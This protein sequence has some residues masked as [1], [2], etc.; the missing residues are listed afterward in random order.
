VYGHILSRLAYG[1]R[2]LI[3]AEISPVIAFVVDVDQVG[4]PDSVYAVIDAGDIEKRGLFHHG[5]YSS[6]FASRAPLA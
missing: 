2:Y 4:I 3:H 6:S 5:P 1:D